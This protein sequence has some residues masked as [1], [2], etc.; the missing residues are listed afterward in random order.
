MLGWSEDVRRC[1]GR[2]QCLMAYDS[3]RHDIVRRET[4]DWGGL[5]LYWVRSRG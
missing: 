5:H 4:E 3:R 2:A 1:V